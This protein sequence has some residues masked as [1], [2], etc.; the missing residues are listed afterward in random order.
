MTDSACLS[1]KSTTT[2]GNFYIILI[3]SVCCLKWLTSD[4]LQCIKTEVLIHIS[5]VYSD[6]T[7]SRY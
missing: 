4:D 3:G 7:C 5:F 1:C 2:N 6:L